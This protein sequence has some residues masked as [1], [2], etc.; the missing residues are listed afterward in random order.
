MDS[1][2]VHTDPYRDPAGTGA[3]SGPACSVL[4]GK[5]FRRG[6]KKTRKYTG[7]GCQRAD[8]L[9]VRRDK[10]KAADASG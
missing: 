6:G 4:S 7:R 9:A 5:I 3:S 8:K 2:E 10:R 1:D